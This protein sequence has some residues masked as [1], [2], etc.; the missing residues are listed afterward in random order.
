[1]RSTERFSRSILATRFGLFAFA[2]AGGRPLGALRERIGLD[3]QLVATHIDH[4]ER[5]GVAA[6][7]DAVDF[8]WLRSAAH[9]EPF[10]RRGEDGR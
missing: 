4:Q 5:L 2:A 3:E 9:V 1:M 8:D 6:S 10:A 7:G